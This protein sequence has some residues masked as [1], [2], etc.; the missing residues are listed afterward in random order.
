MPAAS[1]TTPAL[2]LSADVVAITQAIC[3]IPSVSGDEGV[4]ADLIVDALADAAHLEVI[5]DGDT[6][7]ARTNLGRERRVVIAGHLDT[8]PINDNLPTQF[9]EVDGRRVLWGRGTVD[10]KAGVAVQLKLA[11]E[12]ADPAYDITWMW[13]DHEEVSAEL[14]GLG[15]LARH[16]PDLFTG[17]F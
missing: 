7:V 17:D 11:A 1:P 6:I 10:M 15:R 14:N 12:L 16:R 13:Y 8:V 5:R 3:D 4:L 2:D 9:E